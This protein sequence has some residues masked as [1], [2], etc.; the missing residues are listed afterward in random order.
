[1]A[2]VC[3]ISA[4]KGKVMK[5]KRLI[6][7]GGVGVGR[8]DGL[9]GTASHDYRVRLV[10]L[11]DLEIDTHVRRGLLRPYADRGEPVEKVY[12]NFDQFLEHDMDA[13][14]IASPPSCHAPQSIAAMKA[15]KDVLS[16]IPACVTVA[17]AKELVRT[18]RETGQTYMTAENCNYLGLIDTWRRLVAD[19]R[20]GKPL[21]AEGE[22]MHDV[23]HM[24][25]R[26]W[27]DA[28]LPHQKMRGPNSRTWRASFHPIRYSTHEIGP[29]LAVL[30]DR[31][32]EVMA[33]DTGVNTSKAL[34][35]TDMAV[36][37]MRT[38]GGVLIKELAGFSIAQPKGHRYFMLQGTR[39][40][41]E[42][43]RWSEDTHDT[44]AYF[45]DVPNLKN[46]MRMPTSMVSKGIYPATAASSKGHG[47]VD[48]VMVLDFI[49]CLWDRK[50]SPIDVYSGLD[51]TLPGILGAESAGSGSGWLKVPDPRLW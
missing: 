19:G 14:M 16:E 42:T 8:G 9:Y 7:I 37:L 36:A 47:G 48:G 12:D 46:M 51:M 18:V 17:E 40:L 29:L 21:Y 41:L 26:R 10:A 43:E 33:A 32:A 6:R 5:K 44:L 15:G 31:V 28:V 39:G 30:D 25:R 38:A 49:N 20:L 24:M 34:G 4:D 35:A 1:M 22:Y 11:C 13:V 45:D 23:R 2:L 3:G 27:V 50:P